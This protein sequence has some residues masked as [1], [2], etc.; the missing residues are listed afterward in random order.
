M[1]ESAA[2]LLAPFEGT[3]ETSDVTDILPLSVFG[4]PITFKN[5]L[6]ASL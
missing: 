2:V 5:G 6:L 4:V 3:A 1:L